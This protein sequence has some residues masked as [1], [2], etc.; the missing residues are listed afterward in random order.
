MDLF[1]GEIPAPADERP[2]A[3]DREVREQ[4]EEQGNRAQSG[5]LR[6]IEFALAVAAPEDVLDGPVLVILGEIIPDQQ[7]EHQGQGQIPV[8]STARNAR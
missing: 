4:Q 6:P 5:D 3:V 2:D 1:G 8:G 7:G